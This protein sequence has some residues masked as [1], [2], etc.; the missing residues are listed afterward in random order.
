MED[1]MSQAEH[2]DWAKQRA[3]EELPDV[4]NATNSFISDLAK[5]SKLQDHPVITLL[6]MHAASGLLNERTC[7][8]L[9]EG[10]N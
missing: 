6:G 1:L 5:H 7:R 9:I 3:L 4:G 8:Q 2:L 10:T